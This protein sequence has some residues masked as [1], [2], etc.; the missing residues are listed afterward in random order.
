[1]T[2]PSASEVRAAVSRYDPLTLSP[3]SARCSAVLVP[4]RGSADEPD[5]LE[6]VLTRRAEELGHHA[7]QVSFPGG[8]IEQED[9]GPEEAAL[10]EA[11]EELGIP[12][13]RVELIG[14]LDDMLT[15]TGFHVVP[16]VGVIAPDLI[17]RPDAN[18]VAR[19][20]AVPLGALMQ[21]DRWERREHN[22]RGSRVQAWHLPWDGED[23]WG[24][25]AYMLRGLIEILA[26][27]GAT[28]PQ[29]GL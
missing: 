4:L 24:A 21:A 28:L 10:R 11:E 19:V 25:T 5:R 16:V 9:A 3:G 20:F 14:R 12:P 26:R 27:A 7:G 2:A 17:L 1:M 15:V 13:A 29:P 22:W 18:E 8:G 23:V 6:V